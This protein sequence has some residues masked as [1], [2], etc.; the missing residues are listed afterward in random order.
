MP[1]D[2]SPDDRSPPERQYSIFDGDEASTVGLYFEVQ[3]S[4]LIDLEVAAAAAIEWSRGMKA[5]ARALDPSYEYRVNLLAAEP[6]S[7]RWIAKV[8]RL[9]GIIENSDANRATERLKTGWETLPL[10]LRIAIG[11]AVVVPVTAKP[12]FEYWFDNEDFNETQIE[13]I[14]KAVEDA[15]KDPAV[16]SHRRAVFSKVQQDQKITGVGA[17][18]PTAENWRPKTTIPANQFA[19]ADGLFRIEEEVT[20]KRTIYQE[21]DVVLVTPWLENAPRSW[22]FRQE[23]LPGTIRA[24]MKDKRFLAGIEQSSI[25]ETLRANIPMRIRLEIKQVLKDGE[26]KVKRRG[27]SVV[28]VIS[29]AVDP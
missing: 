2:I 26:W 15:T 11:L 8:Q 19:E 9:K 1:R 23:G 5:A 12:T 16:Q 7:S 3:K 21:L 27:R 28:E 14:K 25:R 29:P 10:I 13:Q 24:E 20:D 22:V 17:G 4:E 18:V 6:G